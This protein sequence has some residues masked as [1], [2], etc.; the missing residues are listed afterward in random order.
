MILKSQNAQNKYEHINLY[1]KLG[2]GSLDLYVLSPYVNSSEYKE[3]YQQQQQNFARQTTASANMQK[4]HL[5]VHGVFKQLPLSHL[6]SA[7]CLLVWLPA[8]APRGSTE[9]NQ[10]LRLLFTGNCFPEK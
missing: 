8:P 1:S 2:H 4:S 6:A 7:V 3:F 9:S 5:A 10:A